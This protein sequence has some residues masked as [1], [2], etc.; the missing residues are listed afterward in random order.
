MSP[1]IL[2]HPVSA[3]WPFPSSKRSNYLM[4]SKT[5]DDIKK[6]SEGIGP[7]PFIR[8]VERESGLPYSARMTGFRQQAFSSR[9][10]RQLY[11]HSDPV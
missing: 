8:Q 10:L 4:T 9:G 1:W 3:E 7:K 2:F 11:K 5:G 6:Q